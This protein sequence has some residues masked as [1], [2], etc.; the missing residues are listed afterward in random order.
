MQG[1]QRGALPARAAAAGVAPHDAAAQLLLDD[2]KLLFDELVG[3]IKGR[4]ASG[5]ARLGP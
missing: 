2:V 5:G 1:A 4:T 3:N